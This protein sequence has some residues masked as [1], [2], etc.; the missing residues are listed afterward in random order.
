MS[1]AEDT[2]AG[3]TP[4]VSGLG[5]PVPEWLTGASRRVQQMPGLWRGR[6]MVPAG[7]GRDSAVL[8][9]FGPGTVAGP[10]LVL[11]ER[12]AGLRSHPGQIAFPGG[13]REERDTDLVQTALREAAEEINLAP[14]GVTVLGMLPAVHLPVSSYDVTGVLAWWERP[15][16]IRVNDPSEVADVIQVP[17]ADLV[18]PAKRFQV[19]YRA[20][21]YVGPGFDLGGRVLWGFTAALVD[22]LLTIAELAQPWD[23]ARVIDIGD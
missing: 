22:G 16:L 1:A 17:V 9:L 15:S 4:A 3:N 5:S 14:D 19:R 2:P 12:S 6:A 21:S 10:E 20:S 18:D 7:Q 11:I 8:I 13:G 23:T